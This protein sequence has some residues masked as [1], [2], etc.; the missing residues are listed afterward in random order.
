MTHAW[1]HR[2]GAAT[3]GTTL[4]AAGLLGLGSPVEAAT[5]PN[6]TV[7]HLTHQGKE[8]VV[9]H[10][11][12]HW[13]P[14]PQTFLALGLSWHHTVSVPSFTIPI[15]APVQ[16]VKTAANPAVYLEQGGE[17]HRIPNAATFE[18]LGY[19]WRDVFTVAYLPL[20]IDAQEPAGTLVFAGTHVM[21][22]D[23]AQVPRH[24]I[25]T[26]F[27]KDRV[28]FSPVTYHPVEGFT[29][30]L[31]GHPFVL[32]FY[33]NAT[34]SSAGTYVGIRYDHHPVYF[35]YGP[36]VGFAILAFK[37]DAVVLGNMSSG[38]YMVLNL[39]TGQVSPSA[40]EAENTA[41]NG[42]SSLIPP[43]HILGLPGTDY[44]INIP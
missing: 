26:G 36:T 41:L 24:V 1:I 18:A 16:L 7:M 32:D 22:Y 4:L 11:T 17:L 43:T 28:V 9:E 25:P 19:Q 29:G 42:Y 40:S 37:Q 2:A 34:P 44:S 3:A 27:H 5:V 12:L 23:G 8:Y 6:G 20:P 31:D 10:G 39:M 35:G 21:R 33:H 13:V 15:G 30:L 14:N 38:N